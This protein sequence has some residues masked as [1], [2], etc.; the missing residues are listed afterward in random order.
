MGGILALGV[1]SPSAAFSTMVTKFGLASICGYEAFWGFIAKKGAQL[2]H[3]TV[4]SK[5]QNFGNQRRIVAEIM[6]V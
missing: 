3:T 5:I 2:G 1:A 6:F 4:F